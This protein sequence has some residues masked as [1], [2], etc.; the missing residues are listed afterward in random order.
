MLCPSLLQSHFAIVL[1]VSFVY[2]LYIDVPV[3]NIYA[4]INM[5]YRLC[6]CFVAQDYGLSAKRIRPMIR[7]QLNR[8]LITPFFAT[9]MVFL[10]L[11]QCKANNKKF[12]WINA[13][14][15]SINVKTSSS[16]ITQFTNDILTIAHIIQ[17]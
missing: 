11:S 15:L 1:I 7:P 14:L 8:N 2:C 5:S 13:F 4:K 9:I 16:S 17:I 12:A 10:I 6:L 3:I